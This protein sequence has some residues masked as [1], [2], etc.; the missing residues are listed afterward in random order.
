MSCLLSMTSRVSVVRVR[1]ALHMLVDVLV[2]VP[3]VKEWCILFEISRN[4]RFNHAEQCS[5]G[6]L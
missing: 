2:H 3:V 4:D 6:L 1:M 5:R